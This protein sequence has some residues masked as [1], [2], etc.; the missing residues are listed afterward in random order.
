MSRIFY[1][2]LFYFLLPLVFVRLFWRSLKEPAYRENP[3]QRLGFVPRKVS[4]KPIIWVHAVSA[5]ETIAV[6]PLVNRLL[7]KHC[8]IVMTNMTPTGRERC[9][10]LLG[11]RVEN[12]YA[13]Y[14]FS[15]AMKRF[16]FRIRPQ[17]LVIVDTELWPNMIH[18]AHT[19]G[20]KILSVNARLSERSAK[21]YRFIGNLAS[22]MLKKLDIVAVQK[23]AHG[24]RFVDLGL[25][26]SKLYV[27]GSIK[28]NSH[29]QSKNHHRLKS[30]IEIL[31][32]KRKIIASST[33]AGEEQ[34]F[35]KAFQELKSE[36]LDLMLV[37]APRH[38]SRVE[39]VEAAVKRQGIV[40]NRRS[41]GRPCDASTDIFILD[42][43]GELS[44]FYGACEI[45][46]IG[47]S[48]VPV[49]G[50]NF[51]EAVTANLPVIMGPHLD[52][53]EELLEDFIEKDAIITVSDLEEL[54]NTLRLLLKNIDRRSLMVRRATAVY[55]RNQGAIERVER[56]ILAQLT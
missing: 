30:V 16:L 47:G 7:D 15:G 44:Y 13:P 35:V 39:E 9:D 38:V 50:H 37:I 51:I 49:G 40:V 19:R 48:F 34:L 32:P 23:P 28:F 29:H 55:E 2:L 8:E 5:G 1:N 14:D 31:G 27:A 10:A 26:N 21:S 6:V 36:W 12:Y 33:H 17:V 42:S 18:Y 54:I 45:A 46:V 11:A 25:E 52:N 43:M 56:L 41:T 24:K 22:Q 3:F 53:V 4:L 20:T